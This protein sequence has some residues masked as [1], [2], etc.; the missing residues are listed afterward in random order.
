MGIM[1]DEREI[2]YELVEFFKLKLQREGKNES[3]NE[4]LIYRYQ[5]VRKSY[6]LVLLTHWGFTI[7]LTFGFPFFAI[8]QETTIWNIVGLISCASVLS[9]II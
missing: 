9:R 7:F 1:D 4:W 8:Y 3:N 5:Q 2:D 6:N